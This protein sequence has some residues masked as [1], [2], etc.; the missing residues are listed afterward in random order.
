MD[1]ILDASQ[2]SPQELAELFNTYEGNETIEIKGDSTIVDDLLESGVKNTTYKGY[3]LVKENELKVLIE[4][5]N[6]E[7]NKC[8]A[9][10]KQIENN[11]T[12]T[13]SVKVKE[14]EI[15]INELQQEIMRLK[16]E[17]SAYVK[18]LADKRK[19]QTEKATKAKKNKSAERKL[20]IIKLYLADNTV[21]EIMGITKVSMATVYRV[22]SMSNEEVKELV[23][24]NPIE[25]IDSGIGNK[26]IM[27]W[28]PLKEAKRANKGK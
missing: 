28:Q 26:D 2:M 27:N 8:K 9:L 3:V 7:K 16:V 12:F 4:Q 11:S 19:K 17:C 23:N 25:M 18:Q 24:S 1:E 21:E 15:L 5:K 10:K 22:L 14:K 20:E 13:D 6:T